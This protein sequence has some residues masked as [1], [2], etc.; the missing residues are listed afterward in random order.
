MTEIDVTNNEDGTQEVD[1]VDNV[2]LAF[3]QRMKEN[4]F[5]YQVDEKN[6]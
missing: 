1:I 4:R 6:G 3:I 2:F 5:T